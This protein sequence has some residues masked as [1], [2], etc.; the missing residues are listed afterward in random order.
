LCSSDVGRAL[1]FRP[2]I[3]SYVAKDESLRAHELSTAD[4]TALKLVSKWL[5]AF[6]DATTQ[7]STTKQPMISNTHAVFLGLQKHIKI[8]LANL[9]QETDP[10]LRQGLVDAHT[11]L[12]DY[13]TKFDRSRYYSW[14]T[15]ADISSSCAI[16]FSNMSSSVLDPRLSYN[17][18]KTD[19][20]DEPELLADLEFSKHELKVHFNTYFASTTADSAESQRT[21]PGSPQ[22]L[23]FTSR[24]TQRANSGTVDELTE[25]FRLTSVPE[26][27]EI[28]PLEWWYSRRKQFPRLYLLVRNILCIPG[29]FKRTF[30]LIY[31]QICLPGSAVAVERVFSGGRDTISLRRASL[32]ADTIRT[33]MFVKARLRVA[34]AKLNKDGV[35]C[36]D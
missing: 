30:H 36:I 4:W 17:G 22:K 27:W 28:D 3:F 19:Y 32:H 34:R 8:K 16:Q 31:I 14:A 9:P 5:M 29:T 20:A 13:F 18:L 21:E 23:D 24:Y 26:N 1:K 25:Y 33:L 6:R 15:R 35:I 7:M 12:S 2:A 11:K 10:V